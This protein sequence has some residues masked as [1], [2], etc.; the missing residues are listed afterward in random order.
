MCFL[1]SSWQYGSIGSD[2]GLDR[3]MWQAIIWN[4]VE[5]LYWHIYA[6]LGLNELR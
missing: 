4:N 5:M 2:N 3:N 6:S 1:K